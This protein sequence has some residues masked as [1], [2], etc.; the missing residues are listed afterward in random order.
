MAS[1]SG[2][3]PDRY[4]VIDAHPSSLLDFDFNPMHDNV[5]ATCS[6]ETVIKLCVSS[7]SPSLS[8]SQVA[9]LL[10][11]LHSWQIPEQGI[12]S[13]MTQPA[14][15]LSGHTNRVVTLTFHPIADNL[16]LSTAADKTYKLWDL[17][18][19][20]EALSIEAPDDVVQSVVWN[21]GGT[22]FATSCVKD[23]KLRIYDPRQNKIV[24]VR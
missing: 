10:V 18:A 11:D 6:R 23:K 20:A 8:T 17:T 13:K 12:S 7:L 1:I 3:V 5:I 24:A 16:L 22:L 19:N 4:P 14:H 2:K 15:V 9:H 21:E